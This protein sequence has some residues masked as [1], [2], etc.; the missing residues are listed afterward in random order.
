MLLIRK[1]FLFVTLL[2]AVAGPAFAQDV[3]QGVLN[4][5]DIKSDS[6]RLACFD[7]EIARHK[8]A[9]PDVASTQV[10]PAQAVTPTPSVAPTPPQKETAKEDEFGVSGRLARQRKEAE[11][12]AETRLAELNAGVVK[13]RTKPFGERVI[14]LDNGQIWEESEKKNAFSIKA[15]QQVRITQGAIGSYFLV[16]DSGATTRV[17]RVR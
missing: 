6:K 4:C 1:R 7:R 16:A 17:R 12:K 15:G 10:D 11:A 2:L 3:P 9:T 8:P 14:E 13:V 5:A